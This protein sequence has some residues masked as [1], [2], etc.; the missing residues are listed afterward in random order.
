MKRKALF[1]IAFSTLSAIFTLVVQAERLLLDEN[2]ASRISLNASAAKLSTV[3]A[4]V[5]Q[6]VVSLPAGIFNVSVVTKFTSSTFATYLGAG[7]EQNALILQGCAFLLLG[8]FS[9]K[10]ARRDGAIRV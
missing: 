1:I 4:N 3:P 9:L 10:K 6:A 5:S 8:L 2:G 7:Q